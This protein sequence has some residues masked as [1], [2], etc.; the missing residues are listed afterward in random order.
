VGVAG[1]DEREIGFENFVNPRT[2]ETMIAEG[3]KS[4][5]YRIAR[6]SDR[7]IVGRV[8][9]GISGSPRV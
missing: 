5:K 8:R 2:R 4:T 3:S 7:F 6:R 9:L 1:M